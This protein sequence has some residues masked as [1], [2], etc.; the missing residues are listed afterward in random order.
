MTPPADAWV[1][2][3]PSLPGEG[4]LFAVGFSGN[5]GLAVGIQALAVPARDP[6]SRGARARGGEEYRGLVLETSG[7]AW[8]DAT[9]SI[10]PDGTA[11][12]GVAFDV[13]GAAILVGGTMDFTPILLDE[14][15]GWSLPALPVSQGVL[16]GVARGDGT[17]L[18]AAGVSNAGIALRSAGADSWIE[19]DLGFGTPPNDKG[20]IDLVSADGIFYGA[21][22]DDAGPPYQ[23][24]LENDGSGWRPVEIDMPVLTGREVNA[25]AATGEG[26]LFIGG[27]LVDFSEDSADEYVAFLLGRDTDGSWFEIVLPDAG[28][29]DKVNDILASDAAVYLACGMEEGRILR[30][31]GGAAK[32]EGPGTPG[33][34]LALAE[35]PGGTI[36][37]VGVRDLPDGTAR[38]LI[39]RR[40]P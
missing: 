11:L 21:G 26:S 18:R 29:L 34:I 40:D 12:L 3:T 17:A 20:L 30:S 28:G 2:V 23:V 37:A 19:E 27:S 22:F 35:G 31:A 5:R 33:R 32:D 36:H 13:T 1:D 24:L 6:L 39:L 7:G 14:R 16:Y 38:A 8:N 15:G 25:V 4:G 10:V 9:P